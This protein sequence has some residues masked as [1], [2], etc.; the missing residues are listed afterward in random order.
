[1][2]INTSR[3]CIIHNTSQEIQKFATLPPPD[4]IPLYQVA[5]GA[6]RCPWIPLG[7]QPPDP[8]GAQP[9]HSQLPSTFEVP[10]N[11][12]CL[13]KSLRS[14]NIGV[15]MIFR[16]GEKILNDFSVEEAKTGEKKQSRQ[17]NLKYKFMQYVFAKQKLKNFRELLCICVK[18]NLAVCKV[19]FNCKL[20][21]KLGE[22]DVLPLLPN[23]FV[24]GETAPPAPPVPS[25][26]P[27]NVARLSQTTPHD[28]LFLGNSW[29][30]WE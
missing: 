22:Q 3:C 10:P 26:M 19:T 4:P 1:V 5:P 27:E 24:G 15:R 28:R 20:P 9:P 7:A 2:N 12:R 29:A 16:S 11:L 25:P 30:T 21:K 6:L 8:E 18:C 14:E 13:D 23:N 17:S